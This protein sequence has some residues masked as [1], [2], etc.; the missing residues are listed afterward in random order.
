MRRTINKYLPD[1]MGFFMCVPRPYHVQWCFCLR[2]KLS[3]RP[4][5]VCKP[6]DWSMR[7]LSTASNLYLNPSRDLLLNISVYDIHSHIHKCRYELSL[8]KH[9]AW[10]KFR[11]RIMQAHRTG[12]DP[13]PAFLVPEVAR[14]REIPGEGVEERCVRVSYRRVLFIL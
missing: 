11:F 5:S 9:S 7:N 4:I 14:T 3:C 1:P 2:I 10:P 8:F 13:V 12:A 6:G